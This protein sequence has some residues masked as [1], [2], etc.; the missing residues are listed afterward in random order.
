MLLCDSAALYSVRNVT[1]LP[2][3]CNL[4]YNS[5]ALYVQV[6]RQQVVSLEDQEPILGVTAAAGVIFVLTASQLHA[7][8]LS[9][10]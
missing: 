7:L 8:V 6:S 3:V 9:S 4:W 10:D 2:S 5:A 1:V